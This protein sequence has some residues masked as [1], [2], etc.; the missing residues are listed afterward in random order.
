MARVGNF[1]L[2]LNGDLTRFQL[3]VSFFGIL[4][5]LLDFTGQSANFGFNCR[6]FRSKTGIRFGFGLF[7]SVLRR[8]LAGNFR[9]LLFDLLLSDG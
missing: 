9:G 3:R 1:N 6:L 4:Q 5:D 7:V 8:F 2:F